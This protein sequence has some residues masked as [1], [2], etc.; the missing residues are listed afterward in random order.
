MSDQ[1][2]RTILIVDDAVENINILIELLKPMYKTFFA[3]NGEKALE[4]AHSK[5]PDLALLDIVMPEMDGYEVCRRLKADPATSD[6]AVIFVSSKAEVDDETKGLEL[7]AVD[8]ITKPISPPIVK[9]RIA[10]HLKL[11]EAMQELKHLYSLA[12]DANPM[13]GLPGNNTVAFRI[14][15]ALAEKEN[16]CV[17]YSD[18]DNFKAFNDKYGF[19]L[20]DEI[21][22]F[23]SKVIQDA[24]RNFCGEDAFVGHIGGDDF[25][26]V[27]PS[28]SAS[29]VADEIIA[30][31]DK[32]V[33]GFYCPED[34][35]AGC[36][37]SVN[38]SGEKQI[39]PLMSISLAGV[40]LSFQCYEKYLEVNDA[41]AKTKKLAKKEPGSNFLIDRR[42]S[43]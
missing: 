7:G 37:A 13:T 23:T 38:R 40:D 17:I 32:G 18:L 12:L 16:A 34:I 39:Y 25:V 9:A 31:F 36:I 43:C 21:L 3:K 24:A 20:G 2:R 33:A 27:V 11:R 42:I 4:L 35:A 19:A 15:K 14:R 22:R 28:E 6:I 8:Y 1:P 41:C 29:D 26:L 30:N 5:S 10:T